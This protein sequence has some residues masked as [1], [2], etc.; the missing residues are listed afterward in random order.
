MAKNIEVTL[1]LNDRDFV[2]GINRANNRLK[3]LN[4]TAGT[5]NRS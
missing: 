3:T 1:K 4:K 5:G 2:R